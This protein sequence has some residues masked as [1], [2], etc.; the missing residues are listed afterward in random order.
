MTAGPALE[1]RRLIIDCD[2]G[3]GM[4]AAD[5]DDGLA[6]AL[7]AARADVLSLEA[8]TVVSGNTHR[9]VG[10]AVAREFVERLGLDVPVYAGAERA[11]VEPPAPWRDR[12]DANEHRPDVVEAWRDVARPGPAT[13]GAPEAAL[14]IVE[15]LRSA[16]GEFT[17]VAI[18]PLTNIAMA[19]ALEPRLPELVH[20]LVIMGGAFDVPGFLQEL[21]FGIDPEAAHLVLTSGAPITLV[22]L[23][24]TS[25]TLFTH[26]DLDRL[27]GVGGALAEYVVETTRPWIDYAAAWR[28]IDGCLLHDPLTVALLLDPG[29]AEYEER[30]VDVELLGSL[31]RGRAVWWTEENLRLHVGLRVPPAVRGVRV[32]TRVD[33]A[34]LVELL[35]T[36][37]ASETTGTGAD[38]VT[39][40]S[41]RSR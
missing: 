26:A 1:R 24:T 28:K 8:I 34:R 13:T 22:P 18:G 14:R 7:A 32:A 16:P 4:P 3:N 23:D 30:V 27:V 19:L 31:T 39:A 12:Q 38:A 35:L 11:L 20:D 25:Q 21:N 40:A 36:A 2:P 41:A 37:F 17:I 6:L 5:I 33:N 9:D 29:I 10:F 15:L